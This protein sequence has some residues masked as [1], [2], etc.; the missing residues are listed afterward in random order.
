MD[1]GVIPR[2]WSWCFGSGD[3]CE[4][5]RE[6]GLRSSIFTLFLRRK[7]IEDSSLKN[8]NSAPMGCKRTLSR[9]RSVRA[10]LAFGMH[11][12]E[13]CFHSPITNSSEVGSTRNIKFIKTH[14]TGYTRLSASANSK[15]RPVPR[16]LTSQLPHAKSLVCFPPL[17]QYRPEPQQPRC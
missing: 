3:G 6:R 9:R 17:F 8:R 7:K 4:D 2:S 10:Y 12:T 16:V 11:Q 5:R 14:S 15:Y 1:D 13:R